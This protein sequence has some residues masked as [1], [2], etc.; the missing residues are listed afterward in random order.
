MRTVLRWSLALYLVL[1]L[2]SHVVRRLPRE[3]A[4]LPD[5]LKTVRLA[6]RIGIEA[7]SETV[8]V[9]YSQW[10]PEDTPAPLIDVF[11]L[12]GSPGSRRDF[13]TL[14]P[15]LGER[16]RVTAPDLPGFGRSEK[17]V[18]DYSIR[19]HAAYALDLMAEL[20]ID[21]AHLV[22]FS[23][24][25][26]VALEMV[27]QA[28]ERVDSLSLLSAIGVQELELLGNYHLNRA[29][30]GFQLG[31]LWFVLEG[32]PHFGRFDD[33]FIGSPYARNFYDSDQR[34]LRGILEAL[35]IPMLILHGEHDFLVPVEAA[36]E[37][38]RIVPQSDLVLY[39][40]SHFMVFRGGERLAP[41]LSEFIDR[42]DSGQAA[43]RVD[44]EPMRLA[45]ADNP[46][47]SAVIPRATGVTLL[48]LF[49]LIVV[50]TLLTEDFACI[51]AGLLVA[52]GRIGFFAA[53]LACFIGIV[54]GDVLLYWAGHSLGR[55]WLGRAPLKWV[56]TPGQVQRSTEWFQRRGPMVVFISR[57]I[58]GTRV[59]SYFTAG[60]L[61]TGFWRFL[62]YFTLAVAIWTPFLVGIASFLGTRIFDYFHL[63]ERWALPSIV[64][65]LILAWL[66][67]KI[68]PLLFSWRGRRR[69]RG[70][71]CRRRH[72]E[73]WSPWVFYPP[74][75]L[76]TLWLA[77]KY[78]SATL[79]TAANP[80]MPAGGFIGESKTDI[81][82]GLGPEWVAPYRRVAGSLASAQQITAVRDTVED[83]RLDFP[84]VLK[85]DTG[86]RGTGVKIVHSWQEVQDYC[87]VA[88][89]DFL[90]QEFIPGL[91]FGVFYIRLPAEP[92][93]KIFSI[94]EKHLPTVTGDGRS[95]LEELVLADPRAVCLAP[96][97]LERLGARCSEVPAAR[98]TVRLADLGTHCRGAIFLDG[99]NLLTP[100]LEATVDAMSKT[101]DGFFFGRYDIRVPSKEHLKNGRNLRVVELNGVT[102]EATHIYDRKN[103]LF[104][105]YK[106]L[107]KQWQLAFEVGD[108]NRDRGT[109]PVTLSTLAREI[110]RYR[111]ARRAA[112]QE[113]FAE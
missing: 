96:L 85:P 23:M 46:F 89:M 11:L 101:F 22:G 5:G 105:A 98:Q 58:P 60:L 106:T 95:T 1:L 33:A 91:E 63:F 50:A 20:G 34:P 13:Q 64:G 31:C 93:G 78:R 103:S 75:V 37:H 86:Q 42:A 66:V 68:L 48:V 38:H 70:W 21:S 6:D 88:I 2:A 52:Q 80:T 109:E 27:Q 30:H 97:Y 4:P 74:V 67:A 39:D 76:W 40:A 3:T 61:R 14:G 47:D 43:R 72:W 108:Q 110:S 82:D 65:L 36:R 19:A 92:D 112:L 45:A 90:V 16:F 83:L 69:I 29:V 56:L 55:P 8:A 113:D 53:T 15:A 24:G 62:L 107:F 54:V 94:T 18:S 73:F 28:P 81:L 99:G 71:L 49:A 41:T 104:T 102:S 79:F 7:G 100:T 84:V 51:G 57:F 32:V 77:L 25:G 10:T 26:G 9:A 44:A 17:D 12:H 87:Q 59:A 111:R 35:Q